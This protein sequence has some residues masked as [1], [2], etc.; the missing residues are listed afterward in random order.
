MELGRLSGAA[1]PPQ[2]PLTPG[3]PSGSFARYDQLG[4]LA[5]LGGSGRRR[6]RQLVPA[7]FGPAHAG[8]RPV[9][10][11]QVHRRRRCVL[12]AQQIAVQRA[13]RARPGRNS[14]PDLQSPWSLYGSILNA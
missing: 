12:W 6:P 5:C 11:E 3:S 1:G 13:E 10:G 7:P 4:A 14:P 9:Q 2:D 8:Q